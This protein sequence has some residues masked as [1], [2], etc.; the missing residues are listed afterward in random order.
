MQILYC[1]NRKSYASEDSYVAISEKKLLLSDSYVAY[2]NFWSTPFIL[3]HTDNMQQVKI[4]ETH[5]I[6]IIPRCG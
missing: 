4:N 3:F 2:T 6:M 1:G 5:R